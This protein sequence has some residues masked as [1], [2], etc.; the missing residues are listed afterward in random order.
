MHRPCAWLRGQC[1]RFQRN[2]TSANFF[3]L[4]SGNDTA[5]GLRRRSWKVAA[6]RTCPT[7]DARGAGREGVGNGLPASQIESVRKGGCLLPRPLCRSRRKMQRNMW[8][9]RRRA[10]GPWRGPGGASGASRPDVDKRVQAAQ[11]QAGTREPPRGGKVW[12]ESARRRP[13][14]ARSLAS[15]RRSKFGG[16]GKRAQRQ[17][18]EFFFFPARPVSL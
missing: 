12:C 16:E 8:R 9:D 5:S 11:D 3:R 15:A 2:A 10:G 1:L 13:S 18:C 17:E 14:D 6:P 7:L 4:A